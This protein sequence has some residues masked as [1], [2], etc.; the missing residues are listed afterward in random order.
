MNAPAMDSRLGSQNAVLERVIRFNLLAVGIT[1]GAMSGVILWVATVVLLLRGGENVGLHLNLLAVFFPGYAVTWAGAWVGL[2]WGFVAGA[3]SGALFYW[4]Y[5]QG[6][7]RG[8]ADRIVEPAVSD[9]LRPPVM[10]LSGRA[11]GLALGVLAALQLFLATNWLV[12]R[13]TADRS[14]NAMLLGQYLPG[15]AVSLQGS[16]IGALQVFAIAFV[17]SLLVAGIYNLIVRLRLHA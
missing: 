13:G 14:E 12:V 17:A 15:Y 6:L 8:V 2:V 1:I 7:R 16:V 11:L 9:G 5:A 4:T 10:L 3:A